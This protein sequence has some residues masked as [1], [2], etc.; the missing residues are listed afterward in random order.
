M[1]SAIDP[2]SP[3]DDEDPTTTPT[4]TPSSSWLPPFLTGIWGPGDFV[5]VGIY[6]PKRRRLGV[7]MLRLP[8]SNVYLAD[9][10]L[11]DSGWWWDK[12]RI[13]KALE[14]FQER[15]GPRDGSPLL[16]AHAV[17]HAHPDHQVRKGRT[18]AGVVVVVVVVVVHDP[19][20]TIAPPP[21]PSPPPGLF[22]L[23]R[24]SV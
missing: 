15:E 12:R 2:S 16:V 24:R 13:T 20:P 6:T 1:A 5:D 9:G 22:I 18:G 3:N 17:T 10:V 19:N 4:T 8:L 21:P 23:D 11:I 14:R 7:Y